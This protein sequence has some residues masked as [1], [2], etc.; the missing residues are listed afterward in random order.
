M[1]VALCRYFGED[2]FKNFDDFILIFHN[3]VGFFCIYVVVTYFFLLLLVSTILLTSLEYLLRSITCKDKLF[4]WSSICFIFIFRLAMQKELQP[5]CSH[6]SVI[7][8]AYT[9][10]A[11]GSH[12]AVPSSDF[13]DLP[14]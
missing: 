12:W 6:A 7:P 10:I 2:I 4:I 9:A 1:S 13:I 14:P 5:Y 8:S 3:K 11:V